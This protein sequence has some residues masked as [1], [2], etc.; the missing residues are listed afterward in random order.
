MYTRHTGLSFYICLKSQY[1]TWDMVY[2][3]IVV[4]HLQLY[5]TSRGYFVVTP[6]S[7]RLRKSSSSDDSSTPRTM[8]L[9]TEEA[10]SLVHGEMETVPD[11]ERTHQAI[12][13]NLADVICGGQSLGSPGVGN[14]FQHKQ[15]QGVYK[16]IYRF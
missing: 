2:N 12:Q 7:R 4:F 8:L 11:G 13:T 16:K 5:Q 10:I 6:E 3:V 1:C 9:S 15:L 14:S